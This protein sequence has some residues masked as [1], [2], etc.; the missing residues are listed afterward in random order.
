MSKKPELTLDDF[1]EL[2]KI[3]IDELM[4]AVDAADA[5]RKLRKGRP[6]GRDIIQVLWGARPWMSMDQLTR[7]LWT[8]RGSSGLPMPK[9]FK[10]TVQSALNQHTSQSQV[11]ARL[12]KPEDD[13]FYSPQGKGSG[14]W[15]VRRERAVAWLRSR[16][17]AAP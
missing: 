11:F 1:E 7:E 12:G 4:R 3:D 10:E 17:L 2:E 8:L 6:W 16:S 15:A 14:T 5:Q 13:L 9:K